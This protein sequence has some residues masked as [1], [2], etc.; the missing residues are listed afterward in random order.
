MDL[1]CGVVP[2]GKQAVFER[3]MRAWRHGTVEKRDFWAAHRNGCMGTSVVAR[4]FMRLAP[5]VVGGILLAVIVRR[6]SVGVR[7]A[8]VRRP[9]SRAE[10]R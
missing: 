1:H 10:R 4:V 9:D 7:R 6:G 5:V 8:V 2:H 3:T